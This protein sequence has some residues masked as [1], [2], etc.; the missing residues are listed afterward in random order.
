M[1]AHGS[2]LEMWPWHLTFI[3][4]I[5]V[6]F[7]FMF[8]WSFPWWFTSKVP[9]FRTFV[10]FLWR[11]LGA[12]SQVISSYH[13][14]EAS[15]DAILMPFLWFSC[16]HRLCL[17]AFVALIGISQHST[18]NQRAAW[19]MMGLT[20]VQCSVCIALLWHMLCVA[21]NVAPV[22]N[23]AKEVFD[24]D[25]RICLSRTA[26]SDLMKWPYSLC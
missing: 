22:D 19:G 8:T 25:S 9:L 10:R 21:A 5:E 15:F 2:G 26:E 13:A 24:K 23:C 12:D 17:V 20:P 14:T 3:D 7:H 16:C 11:M 4:D 6:L 1:A 18:I